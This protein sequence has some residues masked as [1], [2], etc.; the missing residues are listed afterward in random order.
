MEAMSTI[1]VDLDTKRYGRLLARALPTVIRSDEEN[2]RALAIIE[3]LMEKGEDR[4]TAEE[5]ALLELLIDLSHDYEAQRYPLEPSPPHEMV[6]FLLGQRGPKRSALPPSST[7]AWISS[8]ESA[9]LGAGEVL[10]C[11]LTWPALH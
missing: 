2:N 9:I 5:D 7:S 3:E 6:A 10:P 4:L 1:T 11:A 8:S